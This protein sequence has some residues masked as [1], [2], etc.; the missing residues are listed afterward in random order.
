MVWC[1]KVGRDQQLL[2]QALTLGL[3]RPDIPQLAVQLAVTTRLGRWT[4]IA[5]LSVFGS[6]FAILFGA[7]KRVFQV[8]MR[9]RC[10]CSAAV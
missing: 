4:T 8:R 5:V 2:S 3:L 6:V 1:L 7:V 9:L 10:S